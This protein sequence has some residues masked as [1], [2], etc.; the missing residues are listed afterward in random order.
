[1]AGLDPPLFRRQQDQGLSRRD[2]ASHL[3]LLVQ[4]NLAQRKHPPPARPVL[5]T[6]SAEPAGFSEEAS[7]LRGKRR[8]SMCGAPA[9]S[10][11]PTPPL[12]RGPEDQDQRQRQ[13]QPQPQP[14]PQ[15]RRAGLD[16]PAVPP[17]VKGFRAVTARATFLCLCKETRRKEHTP[18][19][20]AR[21]GSSP[22]PACGRRCPEGG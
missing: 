18:R 19:L 12:R 21:C 5:R 1:R 14:Q 8:T 3:S 17:K 4:R 6:G 13:R 11:P 16:P 7:C 9:G 22:S 15:P 2:G 10:C 20:R